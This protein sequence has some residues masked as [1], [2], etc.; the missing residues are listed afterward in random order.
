MLP[1]CLSMHCAIC[2]FAAAICPV[3]RS[4][5]AIGQGP[6]TAAAALPGFYFATFQL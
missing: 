2:V 4:F 3:R 1:A 6:P 5:I